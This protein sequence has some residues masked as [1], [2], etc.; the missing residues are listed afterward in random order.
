MI[1]F[2]HL[3]KALLGLDPLGILVLCLGK[4]FSFSSSLHRTDDN[5]HRF[6]GNL[7]LIVLQPHSSGI[8]WFTCPCFFHCA[9]LCR[10]VICLLFTPQ[11]HHHVL[12][13]KRLEKEK[14]AFLQEPGENKSL[15]VCKNKASLSVQFRYTVQ[16]DIQFSLSFRIHVPIN[17]L[18]QPE[19]TFLLPAH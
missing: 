1:L 14:A 4:G 3:S 13:H 2:C 19:S 5:R 16:L 17:P 15:R 10:L 8:E 7:L 6:W 11:L 12:F 9:G 18:N